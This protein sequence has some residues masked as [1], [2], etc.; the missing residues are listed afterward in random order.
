MAAGFAPRRG[1]DLFGSASFTRYFTLEDL[2]GK[3]GR[4]VVF[5]EPPQ[6][7]TDCA[8]DLIMRSTARVASTDCPA[9]RREGNKQ[10]PWCVI[11]A[12]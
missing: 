9:P 4:A 8:S 2:A 1:V 7:L 3:E 5:L 12:I 10:Y 11:I 6:V